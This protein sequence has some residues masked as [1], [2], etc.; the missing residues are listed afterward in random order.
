MQVFGMIPTTVSV[1]GKFKPCLK[2]ET[3][4]YVHE[5]DVFEDEDQ[6]AEAAKRML[7]LVSDHL[8]SFLLRK[9]YIQE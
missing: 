3:V 2:A 1:G 4:S 9:N 6:A 8:M 7:A 5:L